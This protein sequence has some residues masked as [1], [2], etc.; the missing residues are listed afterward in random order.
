M[1]VKK[2]KTIKKT[3][4]SEIKRLEKKIDHLYKRLD[5]HINKIDSVYARLEA[6]FSGIERLLSFF[7]LK[8]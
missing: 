5:A 6:N 7:R 8:K 3:K 4:D 1:P 2:K